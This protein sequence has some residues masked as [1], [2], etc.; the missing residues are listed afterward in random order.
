MLD[1]YLFRFQAEV[2]IEAKVVRKG[3]N[4]TVVGVDFTLKKTQQLIYQTRA[5]FYNMPISK[6]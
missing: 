5:T 1:F 6:L 2:M 3:R 4:V